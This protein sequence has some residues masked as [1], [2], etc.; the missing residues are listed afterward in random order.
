VCGR[1]LRLRLHIR[2]FIIPSP[3]GEFSLSRTAMSRA[4]TLRCQPT[5]GC[6]GEKTLRRQPATGCAGEKTLRRQP[7]TGCAKP[8][9]T[10]SPAGDGVRRRKNT[11]SPAGDGVRR[12]KNTPLSADNGVRRRKNTPSPA[13]DG[14]RQ[15]QKHSVASRRRGAPNPKTLRRQPA[16][17]CAKPKNTPAPTRTS[18]PAPL[19][20][21]VES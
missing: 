8:K 19:L 15:T 20:L 5:T 10:P 21:K 2:L 3:R 11:P 7:A 12:R 17:G 1:K 6:A 14:V 9:N 16:T 4:K 13:G 18:P